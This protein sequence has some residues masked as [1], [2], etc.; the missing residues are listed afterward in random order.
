MNHKQFE[1]FSKNAKSFDG[2][3]HFCRLCLSEYRRQNKAK[4][5]EALLNDLS[6]KIRVINEPKI[7]FFN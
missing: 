6:K 1:D 5:K 2:H 7:L 3:M 4:R